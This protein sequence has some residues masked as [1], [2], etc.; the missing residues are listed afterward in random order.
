MGQSDGAAQG[1]S[2][3]MTL[4]IGLFVFLVAR[5]T[6]LAQSTPVSPPSPIQNM[7]TSILVSPANP[8]LDITEHPGPLYTF[9][10]FESFSPQW[11]ATAFSVEGS[12]NAGTLVDEVH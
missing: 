3:L 1:V 7:P 6:G 12:I 11:A 8:M 9:I 2:S 5:G 10:R 4:A